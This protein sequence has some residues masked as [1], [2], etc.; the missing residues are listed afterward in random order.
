MSRPVILSVDDDA[1]VSRAIA[2]DLRRQYG[3]HYRIVRAESGPD[4]LEVLR[5]LVTRGEQVAVLLADHRMPE[6]NGIEFLEQAMDVAPMA[7]RVLLTAYADTDAA[8]AAINTIDLDRYLL[9]PWAPPEDKLYPVIDELLDDFAATR[10]PAFD[11][12]RVVG[13]RWS[14]PSNE[15]KEF[16][17]CNGVPFEWLEVDSEPAQ[18]LLDA[19]RAARDDLPVVVVPGGEVLRTPSTRDLA[20]RIGLATTAERPFYDLV[21]VGGGPAG[22][23]AAVYGASE[24]LRTLLVERSATGGQAG[25]S[26]RIENYLGFPRGVSGAELA[27]R[28]SDQARRFDVEILT[29]NEVTAIAHRGAAHMLT[30]ADGSDIATQACIIAT[31]VSYRRLPASGVDRMAGRGVYYGASNHE[32]VNCRGEHVYVIGGANSAGQAAVHFCRYADHVTMLVRGESLHSSMSQY[33]IDQIERIDNITVRMCTQVAGVDGDGHLEALTLRDSRTGADEQV[34]ASHLFVFIGA[35]PTTDWLGDG[36]A[37]DTR[38]FVL[39]GRDLLRDGRPP[40]GWVPEREPYYLETSAPG[41]F[42][43]GDVRHKSV[44]RV[45]SAVGEGAMAVTLVHRHLEGSQ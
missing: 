43:A 9:K 21:V 17:A 33:L 24:G 15:V 6:M 16:L 8:I 13:H 1:M 44:K 2:R 7:K 42:A 38:G 12:V 3:E 40:A 31:G 18:Q 23:G 35:S 14:Q 41:V 34:P 32:A 4:A 11:G 26:S 39:T 27:R 19:A 45:A 37:R 10:R 36:I 25:Q 29:A 22:L 28:A 20:A 5:E 30:L